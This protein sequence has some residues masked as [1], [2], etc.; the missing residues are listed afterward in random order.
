MWRLSV[1]SRRSRTNDPH[2]L[3]YWRWP[4][5]SG[6]A[7]LVGV[8]RIQFRGLWQAALHD[9]LCRRLHLRL[10]HKT[11][12]SERPVRRQLS[13]LTASTVI[14]GTNKTEHFFGSAKWA[15]AIDQVS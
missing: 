15:F 2:R 6:L 9:G 3:D 10:R 11:E 13:L 14:A 7:K 8:C 4:R 5:V 12:P 1:L